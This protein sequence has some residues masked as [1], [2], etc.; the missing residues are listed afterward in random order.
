[1]ESAVLPVAPEIPQEIQEALAKNAAEE[2]QL[3]EAE[4]AEVESGRYIA[5]I[6]NRF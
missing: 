6:Y 2:A 4:R 1:M 3:S 5:S